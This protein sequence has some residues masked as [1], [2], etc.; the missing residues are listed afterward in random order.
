MNRQE[1]ADLIFPDARDISYYEEK[2]PER[3]LPEGAVVTRFAPS[4]TGF[5]HIGALEQ[6]IVETS[7][8]KKNGGVL[9][10]RIE[11]TDQKRK[12]ENGV[13]G[14][15]DS[16]KDFDIVFDEGMISETESSGDYGPYIQSQRKE[17]Y[18]AYA[19]YLLANDRA[20]PCFASED[21]LA[22]MRKKQEEAGVNNIGYYGKWAIYR[23]LP[24]DE[25]AERIRNG[26][27]YV[28][29][30]R[31][32]G[33]ED[34]RITHKD[35]VKGKVEMPQNILDIVIIKGDGL[36]TYHFAHAVDDHLMRTT[37]VIRSSEWFPSVPLHL[38]LFHALGF[39]APKYCHYA[40]MLKSE[41][42]TDESGAVVLDENGAPV[43]FKRK[44]SKRKDPEAAVGYYHR[45]GIP[46]ESVKEYLMTIANSDFEMWR[47]N[48]PD[49][50]LFDFPFALKKMSTTEGALFDMDKL[51]DVSKNVIATFSAERVYDEVYAWAQRYDE[52]LF[53]MLQQKNYSLR[54]FGIERGAEIK[55]K[56]KDIGRW[57]DVRDYIS[58]MYDDLFDSVQIEYEYQLISEPEMLERIFTLYPEE[59]YN[60]EDDSQQ[61]FERIKD[62]A[63]RLGYAREVKIWRKAK[64]EWPGHVGD[65]STALRVGLTGRRNTPDLYQIMQVMGPD[66][67]RARLRTARDAAAQ[68]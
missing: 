32:M 15:I 53:V 25:A 5:V 61:W 9:I 35:M 8:V 42:K 7:L 22:A 23:D 27:S 60:P 24:V 12:T 13:Q 46:A 68:K 43:M 50:D 55:K 17:I 38:E 39:K 65:V 36:P 62:L 1:L 49:A 10:L 16:M 58:Y 52:M 66:R 28:I 44:I 40:P 19:K 29:R 6:C 11:D 3:N 26:D 64:D 67:V 63:E 18:E 34:G 45:E 30:F 56:R 4:P 33:R 54:V 21:E 57:S 31:A 47:Q 59:Y 20:Y 14:I 2:Y 48:N 41:A 37:H 51:I